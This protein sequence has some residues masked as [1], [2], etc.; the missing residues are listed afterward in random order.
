[1]IFSK[2]FFTNSWGKNQNIH[3]LVGGFFTNSWGKN[4]N[5]HQ[6]VGDFSPTRGGRSEYSP[7]RGGKIKKCKK[8]VYFK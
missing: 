3:Q 4:Q 2:G 1:M 7:T 6:L 5:I 8:L